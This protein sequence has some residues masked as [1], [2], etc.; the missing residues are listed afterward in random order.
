MLGWLGWLGFWPGLLFALLRLRQPAYLFLLTA[1]LTLYLPALLSTPPVHALRLSALLPL[2]Y[3]LFALGLLELARWLRQR[4]GAGIRPVAA[5]PRWVVTALMMVMLLETSLTVYDYF[6]RWAGAEDTYV[7]YNTP[8]VD[9]VDHLVALTGQMPV[10]IPL[11][12]YVHPTTRYLLHDQFVEQPAPERLAGPVQLVSLPD[13]FR[14]LNVANI[15]ELPAFAW[16]ARRPDGQG[17][18]Y[19]SR[20]PR[21]AEQRY[22]RQ[23]ALAAAPEVYRDRF[24]RDLAYVRRVA[25]AAPLAAMFTQPEPLRLTQINWADLALLQGYE[26]SP[27]LVQPNRPITLNLYWR[28]LTDLTFD[29]RLFLQIV[30]AAGNPINQW[31]GEGFREDMYRWRPD[32]ILPTQHTLWIGPETPAGPYFIR[33]GFFDRHTGQR[34]K[35]KEWMNRPVDVETPPLDQ[36][37][38]GLFYVSPDGTDPRQPATPLSANFAEVIHLIGVTLQ[39]SLPQNPASKLKV[40]FHWQAQQPADRAYTIFLQLLNEQGEVV[41]GWDSQPFNGLYPTSLWSPGEIIAD[42][43]TLPLPEA[44]LPPGAYRLIS[45]FYDFETGQRLPVVGGGDFAELG[46]FIIR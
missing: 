27:D 46:S 16:L 33:M 37:Y 29:Y 14:M 15:P 24:G 35:V 5:W 18:V 7:E 41:G 39:P 3:I 19:V 9:F 32:G 8:L 20:P 6:V 40:T 36:V 30:D 21:L 23:E 22:L 28:S 10:I 13:N 31:E 26:V 45:G 44:G 1:L 12:L 34:L 38:L 11:Q 2:Y 43:F 25:D 4:F 17:V 42:T